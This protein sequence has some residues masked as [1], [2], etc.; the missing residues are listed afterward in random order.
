MMEAPSFSET[1]ILTRATRCNIPE[2]DILLSH[3]R[4]NLQ[5]Y[6]IGVPQP[7][8][9]LLLRGHFPDIYTRSRIC[10]DSS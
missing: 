2:D 10:A 8:V 1:S 4:E 7:E 5:S 6:E 3:R 9:A